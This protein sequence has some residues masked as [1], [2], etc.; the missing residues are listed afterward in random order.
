VSGPGIRS[1]HCSR[2]CDYWAASLTTTLNIGHRHLLPS[3]GHVHPVGLVAVAHPRAR[4]PAAAALGLAACTALICLWTFPNYLAFF[5]ASS[6]GDDAW[7]YLVD[8]NLDWGQEHSTL[9]SFM[10]RERRTYRRPAPDLWLP[11][12]SHADAVLGRARSSCRRPLDGRCHCAPSSRH[13]LHQCHPSARSLS[14]DVGAVAGNWEERFQDRS[15]ALVLLTAGFPPRNARSR[16]H[17]PRSMFA[18]LGAGV[19]PAGYVRLLAPTPGTRA[20]AVLQRRGSLIH[21]L[22]EPT[23][24]SLLQAGPP[25]QMGRFA[26]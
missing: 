23:L 8:S 18:A 12:R 2:C 1:R 5:K 24:Q 3:I 22:D 21:R 14:A 26:E 10:A 9:A 16:T 7:H 19:S 6:G 4:R 20:D 25:A 17:N 13:V 15:R 11:L